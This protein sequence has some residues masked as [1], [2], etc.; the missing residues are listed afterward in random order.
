MINNSTSQ[1]AAHYI[2]IS[3]PA[4]NDVDAIVFF[5]ADINNRID[6]DPVILSDPCVWS[7]VHS[8]LKIGL[9]ILANHP[10]E[11]QQIISFMKFTPIY[12]MPLCSY[13]CHIAL[14]SVMKLSS[15]DST[16]IIGQFAFAIGRM[17]VIQLSNRLIPSINGI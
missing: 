2:S 6:Y 7:K 12:L 8:C 4:S 9:P 14:K 13:I 3:V 10:R 5:T 17:L 16:P 15:N 11:S 1:L